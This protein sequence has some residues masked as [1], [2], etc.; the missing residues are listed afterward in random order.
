MWVTRILSI[1]S[2]SATFCRNSANSPSAWSALKRSVKSSTWHL[3][4]IKP[5]TNHISAAGSSGT[6]RHKKPRTCSPENQ[7]ALFSYVTA[8][9]LRL[10]WLMLTCTA[11]TLSSIQRSSSIP[12][13]ATASKRHRRTGLRRKKDIFL[14]CRSWSVTTWHFCSTDP[15][16]KT[17]P[18][19]RK[20]HF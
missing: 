18:A 11:Q 6:W 19:S 10:H 8:R 5:R 4:A 13:T 15:A 9:Q 2:R 7:V 17:G 16:S 20:C 1:S 14:R 12:R 3:R